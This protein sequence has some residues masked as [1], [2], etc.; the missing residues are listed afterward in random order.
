MPK[1]IALKQMIPPLDECV[2]AAVV[3]FHPAFADGVTLC[4]VF[5]VKQGSDIANRFLICF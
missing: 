2:T 4:C 5:L 1:F 3:V